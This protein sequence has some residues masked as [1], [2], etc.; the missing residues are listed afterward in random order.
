MPDD[1]YGEHLKL[2]GQR[3]KTLSLGQPGAAALNLFVGEVDGGGL[4]VDL[5]G[6]LVVDVQ[7]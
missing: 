2:V 3:T 4:A 7:P 5:A 1:A 6:P